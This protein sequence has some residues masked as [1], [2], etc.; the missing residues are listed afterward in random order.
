MY[1][2]FYKYII[3]SNIIKWICDV[4]WTNNNIKLVVN[5]YIKIFV[6]NFSHEKLSGFLDV[7]QFCVNIWLFVFSHGELCIGYFGHCFICFS[8]HIAQQLGTVHTKYIHWI[9]IA[10][11][12]VSN[13]AILKICKLWYFQSL[14]LVM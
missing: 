12:V 13:H 8:L 1:R 4:I 11:N 10:S 9:Y 3:F 2:Y 7:C 14:L 6:F 5:K